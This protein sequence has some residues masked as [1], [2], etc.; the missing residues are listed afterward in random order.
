MLL[1]EPPARAAESDP[2]V[3]ARDDAVLELLYGSGLRVSEVCSLRPGDVDLP[4]GRVTVWGKG[5]KQR[6]VPMSAPAVEAVRRA[7]ALAQARSDSGGDAS[8]K[9]PGPAVNE[10]SRMQSLCRSLDQRVIVS[11]AFAA[12]A[13]R[14]RE[15]LVG[16][17]RYALKGVGRSQELFALESG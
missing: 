8:S 12:A 14:G 13:G 6:T 16:L 10:A 5:N 9:A 4:R 3:K 15:R 7:M 1:D 17:G 2:A 11:T